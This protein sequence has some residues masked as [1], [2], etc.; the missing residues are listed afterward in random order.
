MSG[1]KSSR[2]LFLQFKW[3]FIGYI[4]NIY[5]ASVIGGLFVVLSDLKPGQSEWDITKG[6]VLFFLV[7][8]FA[9]STVYF[10]IALSKKADDPRP[11][12]FSVFIV[13][14][15]LMFVSEVIIFILYEIC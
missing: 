4:V 2:S 12:K 1:K 7:I 5:F 9:A 3:F 11:E 8:G 14:Y 13:L 15:S 10:L 6:P